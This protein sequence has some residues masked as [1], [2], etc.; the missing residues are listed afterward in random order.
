MNADTAIR[1]VAA[2]QA[3]W[4]Q[5]ELPAESFDLYAAG[6]KRL[7]VEDDAALAAIHTIVFTVRS[8]FMPPPGDIVA[9]V[10]ELVAPAPPF[11]QVWTEM[12]ANADAGDYFTPDEPPKALG[13]WAHAL[14]ARIGWA[15]F[16]NSNP[17]DPW[18]QRACRKLYDDVGHSYLLD[19]VREPA[20]MGK[21]VVPSLPSA[22][23]MLPE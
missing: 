10:I 2:L 14:A 11:E 12:L 4:P 1:C 16:R 13:P 19:V 22:P 8:G 7:P 20:L 6:L 18:F 15:T 21:P 23:A 17:L 9:R 3:A 5:H